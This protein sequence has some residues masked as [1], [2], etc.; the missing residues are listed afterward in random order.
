ML[1]PVLPASSSIT[2]VRT[3]TKS[4]THITRLFPRLVPALACANEYQHD[5]GSMTWTTHLGVK[6][7]YTAAL[8]ATL[9]C[10]PSCVPAPPVASEQLRRLQNSESAPKRSVRALEGKTGGCRSAISTFPLSLL[11]MHPAMS[12]TTIPW[13]CGSTGSWSH[14]PNPSRTRRAYSVW[15]R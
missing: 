8:E 3:D 10:L 5:L 1:F 4:P 9:P 14:D 2:F 11:L 15:S 13:F 6:V 7:L 12:I